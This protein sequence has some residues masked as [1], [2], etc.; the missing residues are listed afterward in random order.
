MQEA[1]QTVRHHSSHMVPTKDVIVRHK[2]RKVC[3]YAHLLVYPS[4]PCQ[5]LSV[6][7]SSVLS[8]SLSLY[9]LSINPIGL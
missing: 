8:L 9:D 1:R 4:P 2:R 7:A 3:L 6:S 5:S